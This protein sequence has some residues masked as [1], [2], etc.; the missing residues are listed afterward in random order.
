MGKGMS[1]VLL[2]V[3]AGLFVILG[4]FYAINS[5]DTTSWNS[6][7]GLLKVLIPLGVGFAMVFAVFRTMRA[8]SD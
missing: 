1:G 2:D 8:S 5:V 7:A 3:L 6:I 4:F